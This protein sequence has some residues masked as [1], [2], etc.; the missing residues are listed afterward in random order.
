MWEVTFILPWIEIIRISFASNIYTLKSSKYCFYPFVKIELRG[1]LFVVGHRL[2]LLHRR[3]Y[4]EVG[5]GC[6]ERLE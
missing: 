3:H 6:A 5:W 1:I 4:T 2:L